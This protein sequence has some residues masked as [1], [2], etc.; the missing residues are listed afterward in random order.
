MLPGRSGPNGS[1]KPLVWNNQHVPQPILKRFGYTANELGWF[2][3]ATGS[4]RKVLPYDVRKGGRFREMIKA[5][6][7]LP[8]APPLDVSA[9]PGS[10]G[11]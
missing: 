4:L 3:G 5:L 2:D 9:P 10:A 8:S 11:G 1:W 7:E 6:N